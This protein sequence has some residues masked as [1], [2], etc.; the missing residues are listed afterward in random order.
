VS[1][2]EDSSSAI[3]FSSPSQVQRDS[4][5]LQDAVKEHFEGHGLSLDTGKLE[6]AFISKNFTG[7]HRESARM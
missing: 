6:V 7:S 1:Y 3:P 5:R 2:V 4:S